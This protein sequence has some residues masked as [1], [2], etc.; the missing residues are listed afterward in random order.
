MIISHSG[1]RISSEKT[2]LI[3]QGGENRPVRLPFRSAF[4]LR[5]QAIMHGLPEKNFRVFRP[6]QVTHL[7]GAIRQDSAM[8]LD[9]F[10]HGIQERIKRLTPIAVH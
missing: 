1:P 6:Y 2:M 3:E 9:V 10:L 4:A 7:P 5:L 8:N